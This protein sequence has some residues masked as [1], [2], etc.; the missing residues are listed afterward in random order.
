MTSRL[1][2]LDAQIVNMKTAFD[3]AVATTPRSD[4]HERLAF[5][6]LFLED[7]APLVAEREALTLL[8]TRD[9][10]IPETAAVWHMVPSAT[11]LAQQARQ[12][13]AHQEVSDD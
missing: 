9:V 5:W 11:M 10:S 13:R 7:I 3:L 1:A 2:Q 6:L 8:A 12:K 4:R